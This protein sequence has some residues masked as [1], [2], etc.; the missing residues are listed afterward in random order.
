MKNKAV[1]ILTLIC[2]VISLSLT[3]CNKNT[4]ETKEDTEIEQTTP[5][6]FLLNMYS[7]FIDKKPVYGDIYDNLIAQ[8]SKD[9]NIFS[10]EQY[11]SDSET[12]DF[13]NN[14]VYT[15]IKVISSEKITK[16][17]YKVKSLVKSTVNNIQQTEDS[18][19]YVVEENGEFKILIGGYLSIK[20]CSDQSVNDIQYNNI[21]LI[22]CVESSAISFDITNKTNK[23]IKIGWAA[24]PTLQLKT[25][26]GE[27]L[28]TLDS[29]V[30]MNSGESKNIFVNFKNSE[31]TPKE[32]SLNNINILNIRGL[33]MD[34]LGGE[35]H[36]LSLN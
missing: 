14:I 1:I 35:T 5:E 22:E 11:V 2:V 32:V 20:K 30:R 31:G 26:K 10:K 19:D 36:I 3:G 13:K 28:S 6:K 24:M 15:D 7:S 18:T 33:P 4:N 8:K 17:I 29:C 16:E 23:I 25:D 34:N 9:L 21:K 12:R 27:F